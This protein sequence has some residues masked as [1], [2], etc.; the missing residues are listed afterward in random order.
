MFP[1]VPVVVLGGDIIW[2]V[3]MNNVYP[4][5]FAL[6]VPHITYIPQQIKRHAFDIQ[7]V[8]RPS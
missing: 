3:G 7:R 6:G 5:R 1:V 2:N 8:S 4:T